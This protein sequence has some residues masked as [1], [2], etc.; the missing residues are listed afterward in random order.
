[1]IPLMITL[2]VVIILRLANLIFRIILPHSFFSNFY[3]LKDAKRI[4][5]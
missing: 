4:R 2:K 3:W 5:S 1:M